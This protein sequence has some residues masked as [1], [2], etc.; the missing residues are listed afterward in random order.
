MAQ[1]SFCTGLITGLKI[2][3]VY[4]VKKIHF[5][6]VCVNNA[7]AIFLCS[8]CKSPPPP[9]MLAFR[10]SHFSSCFRASDSTASSTG[11]F[12]RSDNATLGSVIEL[13]WG[14]LRCIIV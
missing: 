8:Q 7:A 5:L 6:V 12:G 9:S 14:A 1:L 11:N 10:P 2:L 4:S 3:L 13:G